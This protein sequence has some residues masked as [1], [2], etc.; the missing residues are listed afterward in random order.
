MESKVYS[1]GRQ[2][3]VSEANVV[4][5]IR[6]GT[7]LLGFLSKGSVYIAGDVRWSEMVVMTSMSILTVYNSPG[8]ERGVLA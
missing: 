7:S 3:R 8:I 4:S 2:L 1:I 6:D 5:C